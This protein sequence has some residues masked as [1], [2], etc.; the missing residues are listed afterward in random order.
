MPEKSQIAREKR[1]KS[2]GV[3]AVVKDSD[4]G[5]VGARSAHAAKKSRGVAGMKAFA[6][7]A[8][9]PRS[10]KGEGRT[11]RSEKLPLPEGGSGTSRKKTL[12]GEAAAAYRKDAPKKKAAGTGAG[13]RHKVKL[14]TTTPLKGR[15]KAPSQMGVKRAGGP[16]KSMP[17]H[18]G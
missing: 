1:A 12:P 6:D 13:A 18:G 3:T 5:H 9:S 2:K 16:R 14:R 8:V 7:R 15:K 17:R 11:A 10:P 4:V